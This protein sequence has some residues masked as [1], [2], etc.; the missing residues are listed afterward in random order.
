VPVTT[1]ILVMEGFLASLHMVKHALRRSGTLYVQGD[2]GD[3]QATV[4]Y[5]GS[6]YMG[7]SANYPGSIRSADVQSTGSGDLI[8]ATSS[9]GCL[10]IA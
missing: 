1:I 8:I 7:E 4:A 9:S 3:A 6:T 2:L 10:Q 5:S